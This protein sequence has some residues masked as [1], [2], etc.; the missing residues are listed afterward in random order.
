MGYADKDNRIVESPDTIT[1]MAAAKKFFF[2]TLDFTILNTFLFLTSCGTKAT[3]TDFNLPSQGTWFG[4]GS[5]R[6]K[7]QPFVGHLCWK[8]KLPGLIYFRD[9][10]H[11]CTCS[12]KGIEKRVYKM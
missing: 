7:H 1:G 4:A 10:W 9:K 12:A 6:C 2:H 8:N 11:C 5:L 3:Q